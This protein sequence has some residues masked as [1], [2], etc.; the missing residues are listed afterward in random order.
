MATKKL[1]EQSVLLQLLRYD[2]QSG[3][4]LWKKREASMFRAAT[5]ARSESLCAL[6]NSRYSEKEAFTCISDGYGTGAINGANYKAQ[7]VIWKM[8]TGDEPD[9]IDHI[10][11]NRSDNRW[12]NLRSVSAAGNA[13]NRHVRPKN[14][15]LG[16]CEWHH[17]G[18]HYWV[19]HLGN[20]KQGYY[21]TF[22][23]A[24]SARK[25]AEQTLGF[26]PN[27]GRAA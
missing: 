25:A 4:L 7:R 10:N 3:K 27:H 24:I 22:D 12:P 19:A 14:V 17:R 21:K 26:H 18:H 1:P 6:W 5:A 8:M 15:A 16:I 2:P 20:K 11:G 13:R 23:E 9:Q